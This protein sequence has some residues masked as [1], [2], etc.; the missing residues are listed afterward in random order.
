MGNYKSRPSQTCTG[1]VPFMIV[2]EYFN[3]ICIHSR[4]ARIELKDVEEGVALCHTLMKCTS[5]F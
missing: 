2:G 3:V 1:N 5:P 4:R